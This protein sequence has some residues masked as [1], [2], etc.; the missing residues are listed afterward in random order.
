MQTFVIIGGVAGGASAAARLRRLNETARIV[1]IERGP[2]IS[3]ANCGLPYHISAIIPERDSLL[4]TR[5][6]AFSK[7]F[8]IDVRTATTA[9]AIDP[10]AQ[11][12]SIVDNATGASENVRYDALVLAPGARALMPPVAGAGLNGVFSLRTMQDMDAIIAFVRQQSPAQA[13]IAGGGFIGLEVA[14]NLHRLGI[15]VTIVQ[16]G[17]QVMK[18]LDAEIAAV[19]HAHLKGQG[20]EL[21]LGNALRD[22]RAAGK[23]LAVN[24][25]NGDR[26]SCDMVVA[27]LGVQPEAEL[28]RAAGLEI[29]A[30]GGIAVNERLQTTDPRIYAV[31]DAIEVRHLVSGC[32]TVLPLAGPANRQGRCAADNICG[33]DRAFAPVQG[34]EIIGLFGMAAGRTGLSEKELAAGGLPFATALI[35][36]LH[37]A[38][39]YPG[40][41]QMTLKLMFS[42]PDGRIL[43]AQAVGFEGVDKRIDVLATAIRAGMSVHDLTR[44]ELAYA[45]QFG[46]AKDPV[47]MIGFVAENILNGMV[48]TASWHEVEE[49]SKTHML[50]DVRTPAEYASG[51]IAGAVNI[52]LDE[53][54]KRLGDVPRG[55]L[56]VFCAVG[57]RG[58]IAARIL[59]QH[60]FE[61]CNLSGGYKTY[62][63]VMSAGM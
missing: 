49:L 61:C 21:R 47:N 58:Y 2:Y 20:I 39:Y 43:G 6:A 9:T 30:S 16:R 53:L 3:F 26:L 35:H 33:A 44:L 12:V 29:G 52:P 22:I 15:R 41:R 14:E 59:A 23:G 38:G 18:H 4:V 42:R 46:S 48:Q 31:G 63:L 36:P 19:L 37:H 51:T 40:A 56:L 7:R 1:L 24:L 11:S 62:S 55:P 32:R 25:K 45:P 34:T 60:G 57:L 50:L 54:R 8:N 13:V 17:P 27:G 10:A 28:A 5:A